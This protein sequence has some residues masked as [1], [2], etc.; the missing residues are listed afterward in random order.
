MT[1]ITTLQ[2]RL[3]VLELPPIIPDYE[4]MALE[5]LSDADLDLI[6]EANN[7]RR[8]GHSEEE[9]IAM[10]GDRWPLY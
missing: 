2:R 3:E 5:A 9:I 6:Q 10:M 4:L 8:S 1:P 7:L